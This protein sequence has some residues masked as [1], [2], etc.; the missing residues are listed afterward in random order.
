MRTTT[1]TFLATA[2]AAT[3]VGAA[4]YGSLQFSSGEQQVI[5]LELYT[6]EGCS[7]CPPADRWMSKLK[8]DKGLWR[9]FVPVALHVD[10]WNYIGW[11]DRFA[12]REFSDRQR[13]Y[14]QQGAVQ[15]PYTP[16]FFSRG[17]EWLGWRHGDAPESSRTVVGNLSLTLAGAVV[18]ARFDP[19]ARDDEAM[20]LNVAILGMQ[21][22]TRV[23]AGENRGRTLN[24]D[25]V[26][27]ELQSTAMKKT[28]GG[29]EASTTLNDIKP[30]TDRLAIV[31]WVSTASELTPLQVVGG[32]LSASN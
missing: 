1:F 24:H 7:S 29:F 13:L 30:E 6:S 22:E 26:A 25:F 21:I 2:F 8:S 27:L 3:T 5:L 4:D 32:Y 11:D 16:G 23:Q 17:Q 31:A 28:G 10:Y 9:D 20:I 19:A 18:R 14:V 15:V 12:R